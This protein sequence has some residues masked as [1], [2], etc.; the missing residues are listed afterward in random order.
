[1]YKADQ[2]R[3]GCLKV[4]TKFTAMD[5]N[6][7]A[8][9]TPLQDI[10]YN[11]TDISSFIPFIWES[12]DSSSDSS[13]ESYHSPPDEYKPED[14]LSMVKKAWPRR[15]LDTV[16]M[17]SFER[18]EGNL[19][20]SFR[21]PLY[22]VLSY[23]WGRFEDNTSTSPTLNVAGITWQVPA[24]DQNYFTTT[25]FQRVIHQIRR[26]S[27]NRFLWLDIA[28]INQ[29]DYPVKMEEVGRQAGIFANAEQAFIWLWTIPTDI[30]KSSLLTLS[31]KCSELYAAW[32]AA[33]E[34]SRQGFAATVDGLS[35]IRASVDAILD[36]FWFSSLWT[37]QEEGLRRFAVVLS[38][39][40]EPVEQPGKSF[41][42]VYHES[43]NRFKPLG[44]RFQRKDVKPYQ[45]Y[46]D[47]NTLIYGLRTTSLLLSYPRW[48]ALFQHND[49]R[50]TSDHILRRIEHSRHDGVSSGSNPNIY[51]GRASRRQVTNPLDR[52][53]GVIG[54]YNLRVGTAKGPQ[55]TAHPPHT[56]EQLEEEF[57]IELNRKSALLGQ[58]FVHQ[59]APKPGESWKIAQNIR[60]P[61]TFLD[62]D[63]GMFTCDDCSIATLTDALTEIQGKISSFEDLVAFWKIAHA[64]GIDNGYSLIVRM[65]D[66]VCEENPMIPYLN[67]PESDASSEMDH[68][69]TQRT[70][71]GLI[72]TFG[73]DRLAVIHLGGRTTGNWLDQPEVLYVIGLLI[74]YDDN[75]RGRCRRIGL[76]Q[77]YGEGH[78]CFPTGHA[79]LPWEMYKGALG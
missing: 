21:E 4:Q 24:I 66:Y 51:Y 22:S 30:L 55:A 33:E 52:I 9:E 19:Y 28:C 63:A 23:T 53:Y 3:L 61:R 12:S 2:Q 17:T 56:L 68:I 54:L 44:L 32:D 62:W 78:D 39:E 35:R 46:V 72:R 8:R 60:V 70:V 34:T 71:E 49:L 58:L 64:N 75:N 45:I 48:R 16:T 50:D 11:D 40:G 77:W 13:L 1:M 76:C 31:Y 47:I 7:H 73:Q 69:D 29:E 38:H 67:S 79:H 27:G 36:D 6:E 74:L 26:L 65:D 15:L 59:A 57:V 5:N 37:L 14:F 41:Q 10:D 25:S 42:S 43:K 18:Q 20:G